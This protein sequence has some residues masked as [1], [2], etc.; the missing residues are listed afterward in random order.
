MKE[1]SA[2][3]CEE[4]KGCSGAG[5]HAAV[6]VTTQG[7]REVPFKIKKKKSCFL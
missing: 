6:T 4:N 7:G 2:L 5:G 3:M 1:T